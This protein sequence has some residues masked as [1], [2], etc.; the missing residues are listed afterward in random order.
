MKVY[1]YCISSTM[2]I[3]N[4]GRLTLQLLFVVLSSSFGCW[5][6]IGYSLVLYNTSQWVL[7]RW[8]RA[9]HCH[10]LNVIVNSSN[11]NSLDNLTDDAYLWC[12]SIPKD[13][14]NEMLEEN[15]SLNTIWAVLG[16]ATPAGSFMSAWFTNI[17]LDRYGSKIT[18]L[19]INTIGVVGTIL[20]GKF[21]Y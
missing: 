9:V 5:F 12:R 7:I 4:E 21:C 8:I 2:G 20:T 14:E 16:A 1:L 10:R 3:P 13:Q 19:I 15:S 18:L 17:F 11:Q 6:P